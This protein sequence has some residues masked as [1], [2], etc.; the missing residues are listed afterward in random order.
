MDQWLALNTKKT[1]FEGNFGFQMIDLKRANQANLQSKVT[2][3]SAN[4]SLYFKMLGLDYREVWIDN[5]ASEYYGLNL[6]LLGSSLQSTNLRLSY[7]QRQINFEGVGKVKH[8]LWGPHLDLYLLSFIGVSG[9]Y[10]KYTSSELKGNPATELSGEISSVGAFLEFG[11]IRITGEK[12][13]SLN[14]F[15]NGTVLEHRLKDEETVYGLQ[16]FL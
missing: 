4:A 6:I 10:Q 16:L 11:P 3:T 13:K 8:G 9:K 2:G 14:S 7:G 15:K 12:R 1:F 5:N